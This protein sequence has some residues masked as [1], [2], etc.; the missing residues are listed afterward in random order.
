MGFAKTYGACLV[1]FLAADDP[2]G[3]IC[4]P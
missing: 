2:D 4:P 1:A 3:S